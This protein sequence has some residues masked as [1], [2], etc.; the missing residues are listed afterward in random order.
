MNKYALREFEN[1]FELD[2]VS[3]HI[4]QLFMAKQ[5]GFDK[6]YDFYIVMEYCEGGNLAEFLEEKGKLS[7]QQTKI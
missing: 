1:F 7:E 6:F 5:E 3:P 2:Q 4:V